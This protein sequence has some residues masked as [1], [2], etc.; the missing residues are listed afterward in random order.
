M[1]SYP[2]NVTMCGACRT[3][4][5]HIYRKLAKQQDNPICLLFKIKAFF[6]LIK[7]KRLLI[8]NCI[9]TGIK[10]KCCVMW[11]ALPFMLLTARDILIL[12][13]NWCRLNIF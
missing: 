2:C 5:R 1:A 7:D 4:G 3:P 9:V 13:K 6:L 11:P 10:S 8:F 12:C